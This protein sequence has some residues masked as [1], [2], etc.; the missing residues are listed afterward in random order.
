MQVYR[1][2]IIN[3]Q[4]PNFSGRDFF[5]FGDKPL[6]FLCTDFNVWPIEDQRGIIDN[7]IKKYYNYF[8]EIPLKV[9]LIIVSATDMKVGEGNDCNV[10]M[11]YEQYIQL[12]TVPMMRL[13]DIISLVAD[14]QNTCLNALNL[15]KK[16]F[17]EFWE[18]RDAYIDS[19]KGINRPQIRTILYQISNKYGIVS[20]VG[21]PTELAVGI[22]FGKMNEYSLSIIIEHKQKYAKKTGDIEYID[23]DDMVVPGGIDGIDYWIKDQKRIL[24]NPYLASIHGQ[25]FPKGV[26]I[27]GL[28]GSGKSLVAKYISRQFGLPLIQFKMDMVLQSL[29]GESEQRMKQVLRL[30]E[31]SAPCVIW[32]DEIEK[33]LS[34]MSGRDNRDEGS[35]VNKRCLAK[36]LNWMQENKEQCFVVATANRTD[37]LPQELLRRGRF[38]RLY[39][40]F[41]PM[42]DQCIT[43]MVNHIMRIKGN[44]KLFDD[45]VTETS[46]KKMCHELFNAIANYDRKFFTGSDIEGWI[47]D[48]KFQLFKS[49]VQSGGSNKTYGIH[50]LKDKMET[51]LQDIVTYAE[52]NFIEVLDYWIGLK[53][54][55]FRNVAVPDISF[56]TDKKYDKYDAMLFDFSDL[57]STGNKWEWRT[58]LTCNSQYKYDA[59]MFNVLKKAILQ[60][61]NTSRS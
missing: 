30:F 1:T 57:Q 2:N 36:L 20:Q 23:T 9:H 43:I 21:V 60:R 37:T 26:L 19:L 4:T 50:E 51:V 15:P 38:D 27:A 55:Q 31:A 41:L 6:Y 3:V 42:E 53:N 35:G 61:M 59:N 24:E 39:Y 49:A 47:N 46:V 29:V 44:H 58:G 11:G 48:A 18:K 54:H 13:V 28:P 7:F 10:H 17:E 8:K 33:E 12:I 5:K 52:S 14:T 34:G 25:R 56:D 16:S 32:I 45:T 22:D 40:A